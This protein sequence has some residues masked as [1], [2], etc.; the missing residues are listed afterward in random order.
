M[1]RVQEEE[2][3]ALR[4]EKRKLQKEKEDI[5]EE[6]AK[7][8]KQLLGTLCITWKGELIISLLYKVA[9]IY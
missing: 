6:I 9:Y 8:T 5:L 1:L 2:L 7:N 4:E 3:E